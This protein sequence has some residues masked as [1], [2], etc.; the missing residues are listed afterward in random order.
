MNLIRK[1]FISKVVLSAGATESNLLKAQKLLEMLTE[2]KAQI[3]KAGPRRRIPE[4]GV[5]PGLELGTS[6]T[7]RRKEAI[8]ILRR[9]L[10]AIDNKLTKKQV[11]SNHF[12]FGIHE[13]IDIPDME[14]VRD[15]GV[16]GFNVTVDFERKGVRVKKK[17]IKQGKLPSR[18]HVRPEEII[19][20]MEEHFKTKFD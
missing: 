19:N 8:T 10:G 20:Y 12:S 3:I 6:V 5:K 14:Y 17:K 13:Y 18:Q 11:S 9:L 7:L 16:R 2:R 15:I 4:L 1:P